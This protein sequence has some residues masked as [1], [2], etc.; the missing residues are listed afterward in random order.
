MRSDRGRVGPAP[1]A[2]PFLRVTIPS[3]LHAK[4]KIFEK[5]PNEHSTKKIN[6]LPVPRASK[7]GGPT[8][9][10]RSGIGLYAKVIGGDDIVDVNDIVDIVATPDMCVQADSTAGAPS[11]PSYW[12]RVWS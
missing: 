7:V 4:N 9:W 8:G 1:S 2:K 12:R 6:L 10:T 3:I 11:R 5:G